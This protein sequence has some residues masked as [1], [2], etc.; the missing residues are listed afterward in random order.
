MANDLAANEQSSASTLKSGTQQHGL[1]VEVP[2]WVEGSLGQGSCISTL[3][4]AL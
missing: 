4:D 1:E 2:G 3:V